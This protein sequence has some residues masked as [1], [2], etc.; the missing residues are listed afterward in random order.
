MSMIVI[1][2]TTI[3]SG[4]LT[5]SN[6]TESNAEWSAGTT[7]AAD[8]RVTMASTAR[9][10]QSLQAANTGHSP[11]SSPT[12]WVDVGPSNK[13][14]MFDNALGTQTSMAAGITTVLHPGAVSALALLQMQ[15]YSAQVTMR[16][17]PGGTVVYDSTQYLNRGYID[18]WYEWTVAPFEYKPDALFLNLP[19]YSDCEI[20]VTITPDTNPALCGELVVGTAST[21][22]EVQY[23]V[24]LGITD[25]SVK[26]TD[27]WGNTTLV[28]RAYT[29]TLD[30]PLVLD[31]TQLSRLYGLLSG[32]RATPC[33][34]VTSSSARYDAAMVYGWTGEFSID[35]A[36]FSKHYCT[37]QIKGLT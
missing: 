35:I 18:G 1:K 20:T 9:T 2:P 8:A 23:G 3:T 28:Q 27:D 4:N 21:I 12:W 17:S 29:R 14:A 31:A 13:W 16:S 7:Y 33:V 36:T 11:A 26:T 15:C 32:L 6:V 19:A 37:L 10:Y 5:S 34:W 25:Y 24:K 30:V 22:G